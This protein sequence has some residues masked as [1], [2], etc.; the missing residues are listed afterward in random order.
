MTDIDGVIYLSDDSDSEGNIGSEPSTK[1][2][3]SGNTPKPSSNGSSRRLGG[4]SELTGSLSSGRLGSSGNGISS[5]RLRLDSLYPKSQNSSTKDASSKDTPDDPLLKLKSQLPDRSR[6]GFPQ[7]QIKNPPRPNHQ[8]KDQDH[9][10]TLTSPLEHQ[11]LESPIVIS[12]LSDEEELTSPSNANLAQVSGEDRV[13]SSEQVNNKET[14]HTNPSYDPL[15]LSRIEKP[16]QNSSLPFQVESDSEDEIME[17][18]PEEASKT[19]LFN[20]PSSFDQDIVMEDAS[21]DNPQQNEMNP[22]NSIQVINGDNNTPNNSSAVRS[23][24]LFTLDTQINF[25]R[26]KYDVV[27]SACVKIA[28]DLKTYINQLNESKEKLESKSR[29]LSALGTTDDPQRGRLLS[30][31]KMESLN[32]EHRRR[33]LEDAT[34]SLNFKRRERDSIFESIRQLTEN[35]NWLIANNGPLP[36]VPNNFFQ[37]SV[38]GSSSMGGGQLGFSHNI[39][40]APSAPQSN[41]DVD[42][43]ELLNSI[44]PVEIEE[45]DLPLTPQELSVNLLK[46]QRLGL[47]WLLKNEKAKRGGILADDMGL[48][49]TIQAIALMMA[50]KSSD[51]NCKT[52]LVVAPVSLLRQWAAEVESKLKPTVKVKIGIF[53]GNEKKFMKT[54]KLMKKF[55]VVMVSYATL[56]SEYKKH[57]KDVL[58][59]FKVSRHQDAIPNRGSGGKDY[60]SPFFSTDSNFYRIILDEAQNIK[61]KLSIASRASSLLHSTYRLCLS[62][63]PM[64]NNL[65]ELYPLLRFLRIKPYMDEAKFKVDLSVP[66]KSKSGYYDDTDKNN[67]LKKIRALLNVVLYRR[68]K[69][70]KIDGKPILNLPAKHMHPLFS[71]MDEEEMEYYR[72][73]ESGIQSKAKRLMNTKARGMSSNILTLLLRLRQACIHSFL[74]EIGEMNSAE[75]DQT[76]AKTSNSWQLMYTQVKLFD[77]QT[78][79][80]IKAELHGGL[81]LEKKEAEP[82]ADNNLA[83]KDDESLFTCPVCY[84]IVSYESV[85]LFAN[86]GHV[87]CSGCIDKFFEENDDSDG[88]IDGKRSASCL[89]CNKRVKENELIDYNIFH[90][91]HHEGYDHDQVSEY[92]TQLLQPRRKTTTSQKIDELITLNNGFSTSAKM[93]R[94]V[95][96]MKEIFQNFPDEKIIVFSQFT[97]TFDLMKLVLNHE[98]ISFLRYDGSMDVDAKNACIKNFYQGDKKVLLLS[99]RAGNVGLTLTCASHVIIMDPF[100]N[101]FVEDQAMDRA[102]RIGQQ[103]EVHVYRILIQNTV[104]SRIMEL[105]EKKKEL[106]N[107]ALDETGRQ[108]ISR[109]GRQELGFLFGLNRLNN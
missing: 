88:A 47:N 5:K 10:S 86:C 65:D 89:T 102:H 55:D 42:L 44:Q 101:P 40:S 20:K 59:D 27:N 93:E 19:G 49:K 84:D 68:N 14:Q 97:G 33:V 16:P 91:V 35:R 45:T 54:F 78:V 7:H 24:Q 85:V 56:S 71:V 6:F 46:H 107:A 105:Q 70:S 48:G 26:G 98:E 1:P 3:E 96:V 103:R 32:F 83:D 36:E 17:L 18:D 52:N 69:D 31:L 94:A 67:S 79:Q 82:L 109:L 99:L 108:G 13:H 38:P 39:Y 15:Y 23:R 51:E 104:E 64:Q 75:K 4:L 81:N 74:V 57:Y 87:I 2:V 11:V 41:D 63:T 66:L 28:D 95:H 8:S 76:L 34:S 80:R 106:I 12:L 58:E 50:N 22:H 72:N 62:G 21:T 25:Q 92:Y 77:H 73:L 60:T 30:D 43:L 53:H 61:N 100:W 9:N 37:Y 90:L 29:N